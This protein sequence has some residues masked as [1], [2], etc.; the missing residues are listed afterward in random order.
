MSNK[1]LLGQRIKEI[2]KAKGLTQEK[3]AEIIEMETGSLSA[4][5]SGRHFPSL[6][7]L[8]KIANHFDVQLQVFFD[9]SNDLSEEELINRTIKNIL[10]MKRQDVYCIYKA[11]EFYKS[12]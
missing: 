2:R 1:K 5:E 11:T 10:K 6:L 9:F 8:E 12:T 3:L 7:T 4:I